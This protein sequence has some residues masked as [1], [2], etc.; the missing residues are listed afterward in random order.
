[1]PKNLDSCRTILPLAKTPKTIHRHLQCLG[2]VRLAWCLCC[3]SQFAVCRSCERGQAYCGRRCAELSRDI[4]LR[5]IRR[6]YRRSPAGREAHREQERRRRQ[7]RRS[8]AIA[9]RKL[10]SVGDHTSQV[11]PSVVAVAP[12]RSVSSSSSRQP[13]A[14]GSAATLKCHRCRTPTVFTAPLGWRD[15]KRPSERSRAPESDEF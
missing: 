5:A 3:T 6:R 11:D 15:R 14:L 12:Q 2:A 4:Q 8:E 13:D 7:R 10:E 1:M 9:K